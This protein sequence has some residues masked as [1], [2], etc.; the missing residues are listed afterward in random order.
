MFKVFD[1]VR[2]VKAFTNEDFP[3]GFTIWLPEM[4]STVGMNGTVDYMYDGDKYGGDGAIVVI[5]DNGESFAY[6][7][8]SL[9][10]I[11]E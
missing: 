3:D 4:D 2:I 10:L 6:H 5:L 1:R 11:E 9:E 8:K 7:E